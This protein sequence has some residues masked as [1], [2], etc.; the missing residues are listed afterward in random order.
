MPKRLDISPELQEVCYFLH[1]YSPFSELSLDVLQGIA[2]EIVITYHRANTRIEMGER[3]DRRLYIVRSGAIMVTDEK[4]KLL[5]K[6]ST[7]GYFG[8]PSLLANH[9]ITNIVETLE[10]SL[11]YRLRV[12]AFQSLRKNHEYFG[13][14]FEQQHTKRLNTVLQNRQQN[15]IYTEQVNQHMSAELITVLPT[16][17]IYES[18][19]IMTEQSIS[20]LAVV[21]E[22]GDLLGVLTDRDFRMRVIAKQL[23]YGMAVENIMTEN[24]VVIES[25][26]F[27]DQAIMLMMKMNIHHLIVVKN[28]E[29]NK[30]IAMLTVTDLIKKQ[31]S[32]PILLIGAIYKSNSIDELVGASLN[33]KGLLQNLIA[34][35]VKAEALGRLLTTVTDALTQRL[36]QLAQQDIGTEPVP[37]SWIA[38]GSQ[39]RQDQSAKSDQDNALLLDDSFM[40]KHD[41][42]F[43]ALAN[44]V[45]DGLDACGYILCPGNIMATN[46]DLRQP[47]SIWQQNFIGWVSE[48]D[49]QALLNSSI[50]FDVREIYTSMNQ[51]SDQCG[52][53]ITSNL[54]ENLKDSISELTQQDMFLGLLTMNALR[55]QPPLGFFN[56][57]VVDKSGEYKDTFDIKR[58]GVMP[59]NDIARIHALANGISESNTIDRLRLLEKTNV[60]TREQVS[61]LIDAHEFISHVR[62]I[63][64]GELMK[65]GI[66][67]DNHIDP[68]KLSKLMQHQI[69]DAFQIIR[70]AQSDLRVRY[71]H[72]LPS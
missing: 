30:P 44:F 2:G 65:E 21:N 10:D 13:R 40:P 29:K 32:E 55:L 69:K 46:S 26:A 39:G 15:A 63:H 11:I 17:T 35:G 41:S 53:E 22:E 66:A 62:L 18:A 9:N 49:P 58:R 64:Q 43:K 23:S 48:P 28:N 50:F 24:P 54:I 12:D 67:P 34:A 4:N 20:C 25:D 1:Q 52:N 14:F 36:I 70:D 38:F 57:L 60:L 27:V 5:D 56:Q 37:F 6:V 16:A 33:I 7:G 45:C 3:D 42:Y 47:L 59:I 8:Y 72:N 31:K 71:A 19:K 51:G 61:N 68:N